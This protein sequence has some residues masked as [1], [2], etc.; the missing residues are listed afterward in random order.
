MAYAGTSHAQLGRKQKGDMAAA[1]LHRREGRHS[2]GINVRASRRAMT[3][4]RATL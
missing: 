2:L 1:T 3:R 4:A